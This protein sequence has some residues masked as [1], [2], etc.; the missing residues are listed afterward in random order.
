MI[1]FSNETPTYT[2]PFLVKPFSDQDNLCSFPSSCLAGADEVYG[3]GGISAK[4]TDS[5]Y[6]VPF[7][8]V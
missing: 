2:V 1:C 4:K 3:M 7:R 5:M 8:S 6:I